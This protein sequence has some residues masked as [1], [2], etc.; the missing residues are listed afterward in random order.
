[1]ALAE[2]GVPEPAEVADQLGAEAAD[3]LG[4]EAALPW[5]GCMAHAVAAVL[6]AVLVL[7]GAVPLAVAAIG[8]ALPR[9]AALLAVVLHVPEVDMAVLLEVLLVPEV[10]LAAALLGAVLLGAAA[11]LDAVVLLV[12]EVDLAVL[13]EVPPP[14]PAAAEQA[15]SPFQSLAVAAAVAEYTQQRP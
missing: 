11:L 4:V 10:D 8:A 1:M 6:E 13:L 15:V 7:L 12:L 14:A 5:Q 3:Q 2:E 9:A